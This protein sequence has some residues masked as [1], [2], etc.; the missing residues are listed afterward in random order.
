MLAGAAMALAAIPPGTGVSG[1]ARVPGHAGRHRPPAATAAQ[2]RPAGG[3]TIGGIRATAGTMGSPVTGAPRAG[4]RSSGIVLDSTVTSAMATAV[5]RRHRHR[6]PR[7]IA[8]WLMAHR[9]HWK[10]WQFRYLNRLWTRE[11][12]WNRYARNPYSGAYGIPQ[13]VPA[14]KMASA[15]PH[16]RT[17]AWTQIRWGMRYI[18]DRYRTP[19]QAWWH[20]SVYGWY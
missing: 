5:L 14:S 1:P 12:G 3:L 20:E 19:Y 17:S 18:R 4:S 7:R 9:F 13:A 16:W 2:A 11:S 8:K 6:G 15:G 10:R